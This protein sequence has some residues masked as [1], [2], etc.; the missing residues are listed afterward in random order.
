MKV[1]FRVKSEVAPGYKEQALECWRNEELY[2]GYE[3]LCTGLMVKDRDKR[4]LTKDENQVTCKNC[5]NKLAKR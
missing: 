4:Q 2:P 5:L 3:K 1:H